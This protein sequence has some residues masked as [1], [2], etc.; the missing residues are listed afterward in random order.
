MNLQLLKHAVAEASGTF[1]LVFVGGAAI[2]TDA[3]TGGEVGMVGI[4]LAH[5]LALAVAV[6]ATC[7]I[8][9]GHVNPAVT[10][11]ALLIRAIKPTEAAA[12]VVGQLGGAVVASL[13]LTAIFGGDLWGPV[14]LGTPVLGVGVQPGTGI[15]IEA[16][17]TF[18]LVFVV[19]HVAV[20]N[21]DARST[22]GLT[23]GAALAAVMLVGAPLTGAA[24][25][26]ARAFG[27]ALVSGHWA[28]HRVYWIGPLLGA[29]LATAM[30]RAFRAET[31]APTEESDEP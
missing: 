14:G 5:G 18:V 12:Y 31:F 16:V 7:Q 22:A 8:S 24:V 4:A 13:T 23:I 10:L 1:I 27:P 25:N 11:A 2:C 21:P 6:A 29:V 9:G 20:D 19:L 3:Y 15:F 30:F 26:P 28:A 17:L